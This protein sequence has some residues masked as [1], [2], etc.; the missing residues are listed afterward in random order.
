MEEASRQFADTLL[1]KLDTCDA[2]EIYVDIKHYALFRW[3]AKVDHRFDLN[4]FSEFT[5]LTDLRDNKYAILNNAVVKITKY[6]Q[7][8]WIIDTNGDKIIVA[9]GEKNEES[10]D[11]KQM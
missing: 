3:A 9:E 7:G 10:K 8:A 11:K 6:N 1:K 2:A 5:S 4:R